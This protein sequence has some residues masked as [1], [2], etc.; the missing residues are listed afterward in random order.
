MSSYSSSSLDDPLPAWT[1]YAPKAG[2]SWSPKVVHIY[3][4]SKGKRG[5]ID[6]D[7]DDVERKPLRRRA[8]ALSLTG[9]LSSVFG[10]LSNLFSTPRLPRKNS[11]QTDT[12][13]AKN[14]NRHVKTRT[15][16]DSALSIQR[17][18][19]FPRRN[20]D[21]ENRRV[22]L[23]ETTDRSPIPHTMTESRESLPSVNSD[24]AKSSMDSADG[25]SKTMDVFDDSSSPE[26]S[27]ELRVPK[28]G[29][30]PC[31]EN[32]DYCYRGVN[33]QDLV[34]EDVTAIAIDRRCLRTGRLVLNGELH[35]ENIIIKGKS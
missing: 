16:S 24:G 5:D 4:D 13:T 8:S 34:D 9:G 2:I 1:A 18:S 28:N 27:P 31:F 21:C 25:S 23:D 30:E 10:S 35:L 19:L 14:T 26:S 22:G 3:D 12:K 32:S 7:D 11:S 20:R 33:I 6:T 15:M 29:K 17:R